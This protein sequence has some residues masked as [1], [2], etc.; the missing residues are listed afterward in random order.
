V[1][2]VVIDRVTGDPALAARSL[3][4][5]LGKIPAE[6]RQCVAAPNGGPV[7][8]A[9]LGTNDAAEHT[10][11]QLRAAK[12]ACDVVPVR[13]PLPDLLLAKRFELG[14]ATLDV[15]DAE[16]TRMMMFYDGIDVLLHGTH[17]VVTGTG[18]TASAEFLFAF[19]GPTACCW[20]REHELHFPSLGKALQ[21]SRLANF[22][23]VVDRLQRACT[24]AKRD[25]RL[26][27]RTAQVQ[28]LG[29][30]LKPDDHLLLAALLLARSLRRR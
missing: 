10:A 22:R 12:F 24:R 29:P 15:E 27:R 14:A 13:D 28:L 3:A 18:E 19:A 2:A 5:V 4:S 17:D 26:M 8:V 25:E 16:G 9:V 20:L 30:M 1:L 7:V 6:V 23:T 11:K 21:A